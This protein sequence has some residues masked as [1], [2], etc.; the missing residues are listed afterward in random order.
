MAPAIKS[1]AWLDGAHERY[2]QILQNGHKDDCNSAPMSP[3]ISMAAAFTWKNDLNR[4]GREGRRL[5]PGQTRK[6]WLALPARQSQ[7]QLAVALKRFGD[8]AAAQ[9]IVRSIK[10]RSVSDEELGMF[11]RETER[12]P[13][14]WWYYAPIETQAMMIEA[15]DEVADD[16]KSVENCKVWLL[17]QKQTQGW[18]N[19]KAT[20]D[21][22]YALLLRGGNLSASDALVEISLA[23]RAI[24]PDAEAAPAFTSTDSSAARSSPSRR[25][26]LKK[27]DPGNTWAA[28]T[29]S[30]WKTSIRWPPKK[31]R[32]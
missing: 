27:F 13:W 18:S 6:Y 2:L 3:C 12:E 9:A 8:Q 21:A 5:L 26:T 30:T 28:F 15:F 4:A 14:W 16:Q 7:A 32:R 11:W 25:I 19:T 17:K 23:G 29:G 1:L 22:V 31:T 24:R 10:E 20:A